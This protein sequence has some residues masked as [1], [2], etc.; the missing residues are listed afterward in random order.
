[1]DNIN[2]LT[3]NQYWNQS[4]QRKIQKFYI[5]FCLLNSA[6]FDYS[7]GLDLKEQSKLNW[8][9]SCFYYSM[10]HCARLLVY[11]PLGNFPTGHK[12]IINFLNIPGNPR[13][14]K[15]RFDWLN[16]FLSNGERDNIYLSEEYSQAHFYN[17]YTVNYKDINFE[18]KLPITY[19]IINK[20]KLLREDSNYEALLIAHEKFHPKLE[21]LFLELSIV[22]SNKSELVLN[23]A[24]DVFKKCVGLENYGV[25]TN[26]LKFF[27]N[28]YINEKLEKRIK[29]RILAN[30]IINKID[31]LLNNLKFDN[32]SVLYN[33]ILDY[34][35]ENA[36]SME[37]F[38][39]KSKLFNK[40]EEKIKDLAECQ[41]AS[42]VNSQ[43]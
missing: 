35:F 7:V 31:E 33:N 22:I 26:E 25:A 27:I 11:I 30:N 6:I 23:F 12:K 40:F 2:D 34:E 5:A 8:S 19:N 17:Y 38:S 18:T 14:I 20:A 43:N 3:S 28:S 16:T 4:P 1:M 32:I 15:Q 21:D 24:I 36:F 37:Q 41:T 42:G 13:E 39:E 10:V 29:S 9:A